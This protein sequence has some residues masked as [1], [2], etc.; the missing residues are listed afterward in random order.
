MSHI[1]IPTQSVDDWRGLLADPDRQWR[2]GFSARAAARAWQDA[3]GFPAEISRL[4]ATAEDPNLWNMELLLAIPEHRVSLPPIQA[5]PSQNDVFALAKAADGALVSV[6]VEAKVSESFDRTV[7]EW[8]TDATPGKEDRLDFLKSK[9][10]LAGKNV[11][12]IRYQLLHRMA[13]A[14]LEA[15]RF[16]ARYAVMVIHSFSRTDMWFGDFLNFVGLY[17][18]FAQ[19]GKMTRLYEDSEISM[20][21]GWAKGDPECLVA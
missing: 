3:G 17:G 7:D 21:A 6:A 5:H 2:A 13:S 16:N 12:G 20:F 19:A 4:F 9:L 8:L 15:K 1:Y 10:K 18:Q 14:I 11:G